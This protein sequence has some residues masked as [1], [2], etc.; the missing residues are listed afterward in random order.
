MMLKNHP[1]LRKL[2]CQDGSGYSKMTRKGLEAIGKLPKLVE[3]MLDSNKAQPSD[4]VLLAPLAKTLRK[5]GYIRNNVAIFTFMT[6]LKELEEIVPG[7]T[8]HTDELFRAVAK[9]PK[10]RILENRGTS[11]SITDT[12]VANISVLKTLT[13]LSLS[14]S[15]V[16]DTGLKSL[17]GMTGLERLELR[18]T[19]ITDGSIPTLLELPKLDYVS[20]RGSKMTPDGIKTLK[21]K[22]GLHVSD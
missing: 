15:K 10:L 12:G 9:F 21:A 1:E 8:N 20:V 6:D 11:E 16:T 2:E 19:G 3:L 22:K 5:F 7:N 17:A 4:Y 14:R 13:K 18:D